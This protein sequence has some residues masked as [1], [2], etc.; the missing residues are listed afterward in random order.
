LSRAS[1]INAMT[2]INAKNRIAKGLAAFKGA[3]QPSFVAA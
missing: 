3:M 2:N 1:L